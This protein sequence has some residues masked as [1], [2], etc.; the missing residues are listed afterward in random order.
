LRPGSPCSCCEGRGAS[1]VTSAFL[2]K[3]ASGNQRGLDA[4]GI[5]ERGQ[6]WPTPLG[7]ADQPAHRLFGERHAR[8]VDLVG[9][10]MTV[11]ASSSSEERWAA[12][13]LPRDCIVCIKP[14]ARPGTT[15]GT[16]AQ[17][18]RQ[19]VEAAW[20]A[21]RGG[22]GRWCRPPP[23]PFAAWVLGQSRSAPVVLGAPS[24][25][26]NVVRDLDV[27]R[28]ERRCGVSAKCRVGLVSSSLCAWAAL[29][30]VE[31]LAAGSGGPGRRNR[32]AQVRPVRW[33]RLLGNRAGLDHIFLTSC[34]SA[35]RSS[36]R[37]AAP[38]RTPDHALCCRSL[39]Y[40]ASARMIRRSSSALIGP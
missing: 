20:A 30:Q 36:T 8:A 34:S 16:A 10:L 35:V 40:L 27:E 6:T 3:A 31:V 23:D 37:A 33:N 32:S 29:P 21:G 14:R 12:L 2:L 18:A 7:G 5:G 19:Q 38:A 24:P 17:P 4:L 11:A 22:A 26:G 39:G 28:G 25:C 15:S 1:A 13:S 9:A